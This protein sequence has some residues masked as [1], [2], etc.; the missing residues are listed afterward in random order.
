MAQLI[1]PIG[2]V[3]EI[4]ILT[5]SATSAYLSSKDDY[6]QIWRSVAPDS[7]RVLAWVN[8]CEHYQWANVIVLVE[9]SLYSQGAGEYFQ[10]LGAA[11]GLTVTAISFD[12][13]DQIPS[14]L[15]QVRE[16]GIKIIFAPVINLLVPLVEEA[17]RTKMVGADSFVARE[18]DETIT[19]NPY[20]NPFTSTS[21]MASTTANNA[22]MTAKLKQNVRAGDSRVQGYV[23]IWGDSAS[24]SDPTY[25]KVWPGSFTATEPAE[26]IK[27]IFNTTKL[28]SLYNIS[29]AKVHAAYEAINLTS[30]YRK[31]RD[32]SSRASFAAAVADPY[33]FFATSIARALLSVCDVASANYRAYGV[34][35]D[36]TNMTNGMASY[37]AKLYNAD[38]FYDSSQEFPNSPMLI[39]NPT[40]SVWTN[41]IASWAKNSGMT[42]NSKNTKVLFGDDS[43]HTPDDGIA[44]ETY[45]FT[46]RPLGVSIIVICLIIMIG[47]VITGFFVFRYWNTPVIRLASPHQLVVILVGLFLLSLGLVFY[48]GRPSRAICVLRIWPYYMGMSLIFSPVITK[49][50]R[51]WMVFRN[52]NQLKKMVITNR[53]LGIYTAILNIPTFVLSIMRTILDNTSDTR[54]LFPPLTWGIASDATGWSGEYGQQRVDVICAI[55][56]PI[57]SYVQI[58][59]L[60]IQMLAALFLS[61]KTRSVPTG[62]NETKYVF[63][64]VYVRLLNFSSP[65]SHRALLET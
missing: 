27:P 51:V 55:P 59:Y 21:S 43:S 23:W 63:V 39:A 40:H 58:G 6:P 54:T 24:V 7:V 17:V 34:L 18:K 1:S 49:T 15:A 26:E 50:W 44:L 33:S 4:P 10:L 35:P 2:Q 9:S 38:F 29:T 47:I 61:W 48:V 56:S 19:Y 60:G 64:A 13:A 36:A 37:T 42:W 46:S 52:A 57:W 31:G 28:A 3:F 22:T 32:Q 5:Y 8:L 53:R 20:N 12:S 30:I 41:T 65:A 11:A 25:A 45:I 14:A 62:F 16:S